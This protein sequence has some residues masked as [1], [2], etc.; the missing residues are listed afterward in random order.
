MIINVHALLPLQ[1]PKNVTTLEIHSM[2]FRPT[3]STRTILKNTGESLDTIRKLIIHDFE[4]SKKEIE[5][6]EQFKNLEYLELE[7]PEI[8]CNYLKFNGK[9]PQISIK[10]HAEITIKSDQ[11]YIKDLIPLIDK[12][13]YV[14]LPKILKN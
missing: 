10:T 9:L 11:M 5:F 3:A 8:I 12:Y 2:G 1:L 7:R 4:W 6:I 14:R 13:N